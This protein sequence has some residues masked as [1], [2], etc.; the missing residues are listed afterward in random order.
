[1]LTYVIEF[2]EIES[3]DVVVMYNY[4]LMLDIKVFFFHHHKYFCSVY[5]DVKVIC[6]VVIK[7]ACLEQL[8]YTYISLA[9]LHV[10]FA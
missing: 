4:Y 7:N 3:T 6:K 5:R 2:E 8:L 10:L 9:G 1:M